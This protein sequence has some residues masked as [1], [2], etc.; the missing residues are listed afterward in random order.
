MKRLC[1]IAV[2][3]VVLSVSTTHAAGNRSAA[4]RSGNRGGFFS[5]LMELERRKN[6]RIR[7]FFFGR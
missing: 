6:E 4:Y 7:Q 5:R 3:L 1:L 2:A